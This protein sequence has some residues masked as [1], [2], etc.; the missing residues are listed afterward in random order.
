M[1]GDSCLRRIA[2][3]IAEALRDSSGMA[4]R[5]GGE[6]FAVILPD[7]DG[8]GALAVAESIR[9]AVT[10][11]NLPHGGSPWGI[12][13]ISIGVAAMVPNGADSAMMLL[14]ASDNALYC[15]K[16]LGRNRVESSVTTTAVM[17]GSGG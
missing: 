3:V 10:T 4:S 1:R 5:F 12:Q 14:N 13:T 16:R 9:G 7:T 6:E 8:E 15:A 17:N 11:L 2:G